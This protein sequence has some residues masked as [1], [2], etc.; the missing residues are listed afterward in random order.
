LLQPLCRLSLVSDGCIMMLSLSH[1]F[2]HQL[3]IGD[4]LS[5]LHQSAFA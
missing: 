3:M 1:Q 5:P 4:S 2:S